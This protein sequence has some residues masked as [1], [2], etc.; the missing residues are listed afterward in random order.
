MNGG[1]RETTDIKLSAKGYSA[2]FLPRGPKERRADSLVSV[3]LDVRPNE[4][5]SVIGPARSGKTTLLRSINRLNDIAPNFSHSGDITIDGKSIYAPGTDVAELRRRAGMVFARPVALPKSIYENIVYGARLKGVRDRAVL[6]SIVEGSLRSA[7]LWDEVKNRLK[8]SAL[9]LSG[10][11][12]QRLCIARVIALNPEI[13]MLDEP[14]SA[15]DPISTSKIEDTL[16]ELKAKYTIILVTNNTKQ[17]AR[18]GDRSAFFLTGEL[19]ETGPTEEM[20][21]N[22][23]DRRTEDY[24]TGRF[25]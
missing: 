21:T 4:I 3:T 18:I 7:F 14:T 10:G 23:R 24:I 17:A 20:F 19:V 6:D 1:P 8:A 2:S 5:L 22:P 9:A 12:Q 13:I 25:G 15:L 11:Q 16:T